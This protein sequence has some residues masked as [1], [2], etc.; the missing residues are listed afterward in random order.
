MDSL[1]L[2]YGFGSTLALPIHSFL[3]ELDFQNDA[4]DW[5]VGMQHDGLLPG[6]HPHNIVAL[7]WLD[8]GLFGALLISFFA[9][10][11][12]TWLMPYIECHQ[13]GSFI[14]GLLSSALVI[15][16]FSFSIWQTDV[17]ITY[18]MFF[19]SVMII[20]SNKHAEVSVK[21]YRFH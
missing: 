10:K 6:G 18:A 12:Y 14:I 21:N 7:I 1:Y 8:W 4:R 20:I 19:V 17:V 16:S 11:F 3:P 5:L 2:G 15:F 9:Y 13:K